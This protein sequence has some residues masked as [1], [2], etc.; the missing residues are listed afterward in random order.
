MLI[1]HYIYAAIMGIVSILSI[2]F[3]SWILHRLELRSASQGSTAWWKTWQRAGLLTLVAFILG[4]IGPQMPP[5]EHHLIGAVLFLFSCFILP[6]VYREV[7]IGSKSYRIEQ[8]AMWSSWLSATVLVGTSL[9][10]FSF[11]ALFMWAGGAILGG[12]IIRLGL[13]GLYEKG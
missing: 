13:Y 7:G 12:R 2:A 5:F 10:Y 3:S 6:F 4:L 9:I 1:L 11:Y 8:F